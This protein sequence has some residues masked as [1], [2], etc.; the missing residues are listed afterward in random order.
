[1]VWRDVIALDQIS[2]PMRRGCTR[3]V[4]RGI[5]TL[6]THRS[7]PRGCGPNEQSASARDLGG[8]ARR[9]GGWTLSR[10]GGESPPAGL[11]LDRRGIGAGGGVGAG[12]L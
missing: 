6:T 12:G 3:G 11:F 1:V 10:R 8:K 4:R 9:A 5:W 7:R 2:D